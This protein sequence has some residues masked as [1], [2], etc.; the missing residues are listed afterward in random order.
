MCGLSSVESYTALMSAVSTPIVADVSDAKH[1]LERLPFANFVYEYF[2]MKFGQ[3]YF[4]EINLY[5]MLKLLSEHAMQSP[6]LHQFSAFLGLDV[7]LRTTPEHLDFY[8]S[9]FAKTLN[10]APD[11]ERTSI[12]IGGDKISQE[13]CMKIGMRMAER[14]NAPEAIAKD[15]RVKIEALDADTNGRVSFD[16]YLWHMMHFY[17]EM[18]EENMEYARQLFG[19]ADADGDGSL[20]FDEFQDIVNELIKTQTIDPTLTVRNIE[21]MFSEAIKM[22]QGV[23]LTP[24][25]FC[26]AITSKSVTKSRM[27]QTV[28]PIVDDAI[29]NYIV[30][31]Q[32][33]LEE[34]WDHIKPFLRRK[35]DKIYMAAQ[36]ANPDAK[37]ETSQI[38]GQQH[39]QQQLAQQSAVMTAMME[40]VQHPIAKEA[41]GNVAGSSA[42]TKGDKELARWQKLPCC[43]YSDSN[44]YPP[45]PA[46]LEKRLPQL[47]N[48]YGDKT[49]DRLNK[50][51]SSLKYEQLVLV[52]AL[53]YLYDAVQFSDDILEL[54]KNQ[55]K[56]HALAQEIEQRV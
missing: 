23:A 22:C 38:E 27:L 54:L 16:N 53:V 15:L 41:E 33:L 25:A 55:D 14:L 21:N 51:S 37:R 9:I 45:R 56:Q 24:E 19:K 48:L 29:T 40:Q 52:P 47:Y 20:S 18:E 49:F 35:L 42:P 4:A 32:A 3:R 12:R 6:R 2:V 11:A 43:P 5:G 34:S 36:L 28:V 50:Y 7:S 39:Y 17:R 46:P 30:F 31:D 10:A 13:A 26:S 8:L 1:S 44:P